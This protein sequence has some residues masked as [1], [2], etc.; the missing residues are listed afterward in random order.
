VTA[1]RPLALGGQPRGPV[2]VTVRLAGW[3]AVLG[4]R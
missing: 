1:E 3:S 4:S 2:A